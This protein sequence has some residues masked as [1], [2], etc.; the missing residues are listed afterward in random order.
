MEPYI[1][2]VGG[3]KFYFLDPKEDDF[4]ITDIAHALS[5]NC[6]YTGQCS[7]FYSVAEHSVHVSRLLDGTGLELD[8]LL[9]DASEAYI[10]DIASP[11]KQ[12]LPDYLK[13][14]DGIMLAFFKKYGLEYPLHPAVKHCDRVMLST[15][16]WHLLPSQGN[17]WD[18]WGWPAS[19][20]KIEAG[21]RPMCLEPTVAKNLFLERFYEL[22]ENA[23]TNEYT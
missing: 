13:M 15:E 5:Q 8:G 14:E 7:K 10:T 19:R 3:K 21:I 6:R 12:F 20:P 2:T 18:M 1:E 4:D 17:T 23:K 9:H 22:T 16:A 11:I